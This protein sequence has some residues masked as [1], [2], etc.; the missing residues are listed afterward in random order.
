MSYAFTF[1]NPCFDWNSGLSGMRRRAVSGL[2]RS[3]RI[4]VLKTL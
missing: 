3:V 1:S 4:C 2:S